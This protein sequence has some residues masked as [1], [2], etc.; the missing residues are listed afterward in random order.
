[1]YS[2]SRFFWQFALAV[3]VLATASVASPGQAPA[4]LTLP[5]TAAQLK[6]TPE[7]VGD[8]L[9]T[10]QRYQAAIES[11]KNASQTTP[12]TWNKMGVAYQLM[13]NVEEAAR[14][15]KKA[16]KLDP[17]SA[18]ATNNLGSIY[19]EQKNYKAAQKTYRKA[20]K[21][22]PQSALFRKNLGTALLAAHQY[23]KGW[24]AYQ[25]ALAIDP[26][27]FTRV[28]GSVRVENPSTIQDRGAMNYYMAKGCLRAGMN[29]RAI[30]YLRL[31][32]N[33]GFVSPKKLVSDNEFA[34]LRDLPKFQQLLN[35]LGASDHD[36]STTTASNEV[37]GR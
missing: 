7:Q 11:Y 9:M 26:N 35:S 15:Y 20:V 24:E 36:S 19:M 4:K 33:E 8:S 22:N 23:K 1:M 10:H 18:I 12:E 14:C 13:Y 31:A 16:L 25:Q 17:Q 37:S 5:N 3:V 28:G 30:E 6:P 34:S 29:D 21:L 2:F 32:V 27:I